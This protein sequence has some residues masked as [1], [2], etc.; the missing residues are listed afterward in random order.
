MRAD[1]EACVRILFHH[2]PWEPGSPFTSQSLYFL[3]C[4]TGTMDRALP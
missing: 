2:F 1:E 3:S 4:K